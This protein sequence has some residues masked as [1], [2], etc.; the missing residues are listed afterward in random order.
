MIVHSS[1]VARRGLGTNRTWLGFG[2][3][4]GLALKILDY[5]WERIV[6]MVDRNQLTVC[7][8]W[9]E[10]GGLLMSESDVWLTRPSTVTSSLCALCGLCSDDRIPA[11]AARRLCHVS[12]IRGFSTLTDITL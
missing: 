4:D 2:R 5:V 9:K 12:L 6:F 10:K 11:A 3:D 8:K 7:R 1:V